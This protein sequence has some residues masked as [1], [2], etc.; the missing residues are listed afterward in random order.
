MNAIENVCPIC[1]SKNELDA[2][3][4]AYC[5]TALENPLMNHGVST[6]TAEMPV[7]THG[8]STDWT[9]DETTIPAFGIAVYLEGE[10]NPIHADANNEFIIGRRA[11]GTSQVMI[12]EDLLDLAPLGGYSRG[13]SRR[14]VSIRRT[15]HGYEILDLGSVNG[16]WLN[17]ERLTPHK[18]YPLKSG[19]HLRLGSMR[20][21]VLYRPPA[22]VE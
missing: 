6:Q 9:V 4:C 7:A 13:V 20:F 15:D 21:F 19:S 16:T 14:H 18:Y 5:G 8:G 10:P 17:D 3:I 12:V 2:V 1:H 11:G 22:D